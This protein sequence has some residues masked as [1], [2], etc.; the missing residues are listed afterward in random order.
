MDAFGDLSWASRSQNDS[1]SPTPVASGTSSAFDSFASLTPMATGS[2][3]KKIHSMSLQERQKLLTEQKASQQQSNGNQTSIAD[4]WN[5]LDLLAGSIADSERRPH[6]NDFEQSQEKDDLDEIFDV[7]N[8]PPP[9]PKIEVTEPEPDQ[10]VKSISQTSSQPPSRPPSRRPSRPSSRPSSQPVSQPVSETPSRAPS[11]TDSRRPTPA[12]RGIPDPRDPY[13]AELVDM[14]FSIEQARYALAQTDNGLDVQQAVEV[15][16]EEAHRSTRESSRTNSRNAQRETNQD[17][18]TLAQEF[19]ST[20]ISKAGSFWSQ[21]RKNL[22][23]AIEQY[24]SGSPSEESVPAWMRENP[25]Y[26]L[27]SKPE[28]TATEEAMMLESG[29]R[30]RRQH[31]TTNQPSQLDRAA[32]MRQKQRERMSD[33]D[34]DLYVPLARRKPKQSDEE[35]YVSSGRKKSSYEEDTYSSSGRKK[36]PDEEDIYSRK[37]SISKN[38]NHKVLSTTAKKKPSDEEMYVSSRRRATPKEKTPLPPKTRSSSESPKKRPPVAE[39]SK[40]KPKPVRVLPVISSSALD[41]SNAARQSGT[42]AFKRG[43]FAQAITH[44]SQA[45][46]GIPPKHT[47][48]TIIL[49][50]RA[51]CYIK[52]GDSKTAIVDSEHALLVIGPGLGVGEEV[53]PGK[54]LNEIWSKVVGRKA[55]AYEHLEKF[56]DAL[57]AWTLLINN[58]YSNKMSLDGRRRCQSALQPAI[59]KAV[60]RASTPKSIGGPSSEAGKAAVERVK[61]QNRAAETADNERFALHDRVNPKIDNWKNGKEDNLRALLASLD[62]VLW[63]EAGW[64]KVS[65]AELVVPKKVKIIY[66]KAVAKTHPDKVTSS[67]TTEQ[68]MISEAVFVT[69]NKAWDQFKAANDIS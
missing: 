6:T 39:P 58:G 64:N 51:A 48:R 68:K 50:N 55:E 60:S 36:R 10:T 24:S 40:P 53:E 26:T 47:L 27:S 44:Y 12:T 57:D 46:E 43:D 59:A 23:K 52:A 56:Q 4:N 30:S 5:G 65:M 9:P 49:S 62:N 67:A 38:E 15:L 1:K 33:E 32:Q 35:L 14:G 19:S 18:G 45:L 63:V 28:S 11:R 17:I 34:D 42:E 69:L 20:F 31:P 29:R 66:M 25:H 54:S 22:A 61:L 37:E 16:M 8:K 7:F 13:I 2:K 3:P 41:I 21:G